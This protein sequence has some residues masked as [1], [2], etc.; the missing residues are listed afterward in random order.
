V[1]RES[2]GESELYPYSR[3]E[4]G[5]PAAFLVSVVDAADYRVYGLAPT[6]TPP[7]RLGSALLDLL[8]DQDAATS[9]QHIPGSGLHLDTV[10]RTAGIWSI[11]ALRD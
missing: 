1:R 5:S 9:F 3:G 2:P 8:S 10:R 7:W 11:D 4:P 6:A